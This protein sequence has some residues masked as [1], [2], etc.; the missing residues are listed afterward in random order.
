[1]PLVA[2]GVD[3]LIPAGGIPMLLLSKLKSH[4]VAGAPILNG[5]P[6]ALRTCEMAVEM[7]QKFGL[8]VS[9]TPE[10][11]RPPREVLDEF[12]NNPRG[13]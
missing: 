3:V 7:R 6:L 9:R 10:F 1:M 5:L 12:L 4:R 11:V 2:S 13:L 8:E